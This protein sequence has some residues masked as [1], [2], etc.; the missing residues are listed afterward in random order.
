MLFYRKPST[1]TI[2]ALNYV[3]NNSGTTFFMRLV[4]PS[5][6]SL[7]CHLTGQMVRI[8]NS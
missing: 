6:R 1:K 7:M 8:H 2:A 5:V 3:Q 4:F